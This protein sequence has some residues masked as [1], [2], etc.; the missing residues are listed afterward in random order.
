MNIALLISTFLLGIGG[1]LHCV[2]MC[3][4][5]ALAVPFGNGAQKKWVAILVYYLSKAMGYGLMGAVLGVLGKGVFL[6]DWQRGLSIIAGIFVVLL[7]CFPLLKGR[8]GKFIFQRQYEKLFQV[9][10]LRPMLMHFSLLGLLN[11]FLPCGLVYAALA[12]A[13]VSGGVIQ[14]FFAMFLFGIGTMPLLIALA[15][16]GTRINARYKTSLLSVSKIMSVVIGVL[17]IL[18]GLNLGIPY[19]SPHTDNGEVKSCCSKGHP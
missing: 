16:F 14:G 11:S 4:P 1:S 19:V 17:L 8:S 12:V 13:I 6:M 3:G 2:G 18:R 15:A 5:L 9:M 7:V 10:R